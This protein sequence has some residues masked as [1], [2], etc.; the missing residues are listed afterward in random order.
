MVYSLESHDPSTDT[1][2]DMA[3]LSKIVTVGYDWLYETPEFH[4]YYEEANEKANLGVTYTKDATTFR[5]WSPVAAN[6]NVLIY[7]YD[8]SSEYAPKP[9]TDDQKK[10]YNK[11]QGYHM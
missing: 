6:M 10:A 1:D 4:T 11:Y 7:D 9:I 8:T 3:A 5:V 2:P